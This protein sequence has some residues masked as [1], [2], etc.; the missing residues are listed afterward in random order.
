MLAPEKA[1]VQASLFARVRVPKLERPK[2]QN[3]STLN[4]PGTPYLA[5]SGETMTNVLAVGPKPLTRLLVSSLLGVDSVAVTT[6]SSRRA[7]RRLLRAHQ[8]PLVV[9]EWQT[10]GRE[11]IAMLSQLHVPVILISG[12]EHLAEA[13]RLAKSV[14]VVLETPV[15]CQEITALAAALLK[16][17]KAPQYEKD[18]KQQKA[19]PERPA[20]AAKS[21]GR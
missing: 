14:E 8:F 13:Y 5:G 11:G 9:A 15:N 18:P 12:P 16:G 6:C 21:A 7:L 2:E 19:P 20:T 10:C 17:E 4:P 3:W 1:G